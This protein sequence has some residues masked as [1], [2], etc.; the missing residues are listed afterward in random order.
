MINTLKKISIQSI[1][2]RKVNYHSKVKVQLH[3]EPAEVRDH[4]LGTRAPHK[5]VINYR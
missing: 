2:T 1:D 3:G 5:V 4:Y